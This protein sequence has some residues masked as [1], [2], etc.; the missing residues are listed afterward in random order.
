MAQTVCSPNPTVVE[1]A[2]SALVGKA[3]DGFSCIGAT[4]TM[5]FS[6]N[7]GQEASLE[8]CCAVDLA[9]PEMVAQLSDRDFLLSLFDNRSATVSTVEISTGHELLLTL[10][11]GDRYVIG[12]RDSGSDWPW[13]LRS[14][15]EG[16]RMRLT[17]ELGGPIYIS[18]E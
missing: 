4:T 16:S 1:A 15:V 17:R 11:T 8:L 18:P 14:S 13:T 7:D 2:R 12:E 5:I 9:T 6:S 3:L 10:S